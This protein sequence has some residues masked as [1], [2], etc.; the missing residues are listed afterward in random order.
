M[1]VSMRPITLFVFLSALPV[2]GARVSVTLDGKAVD[3]AEVCRWKAGPTVNPAT[4]FFTSSTVECHASAEDVPADSN[5][6]AR[7]GNALIS[8]GPDL[9]LVPAAKINATVPSGAALFVYVPRTSFAIPGNV[10]PADT[11]VIPVLVKDGKVIVVANRVNVP[12]GKSVNVAFDAPRANRVDAVVPVVFAPKSDPSIEAPQAVI[13]EKDKPIVALNKGTDAALLFFRDVAPAKLKLSGKRWKTTEVAVAGGPVVTLDPITATQ[14]SKLIVNWWGSRAPDSLA[15]KPNDCKPSKRAFPYMERWSTEPKFVALVSNCAADPSR[16]GTRAQCKEMARHDLEGPALRGTFEIEDVPAGNYSI[17]IHHPGLP[18]IGKR[19]EVTSAETTAVDVPLSYIT[20]FGKITRAGKP[21]HAMAFN[22]VTDPETGAYDAVVTQIPLVNNMVEV[23]PCDGSATYKFVLDERPKE[24]AAFDIVMP[25]NRIHVE[26]YDKATGA[27]VSKASVGFGA[28]VPGEKFSAH[29]M[30][31][32]GETDDD[33]KM[34]ISPVLQNRMVKVCASREDYEGP[35]EP[36]FKMEDADKTVR[37]GLAKIAIRHGRVNA[38]P[39]S[40]GQLVWVS[41]TTGSITEMLRE[42]KED[43]SFVYKKEHP[44]GEI[45]A[46]SAA[47]RPLYAFIQPQVAADGMFEITLPAAPVRSFTVTLADTSKERSA[48]VELSI[49]NVV[50]PGAGLAS[51]FMFR[52]MQSSLRPGE[53]LLVPDILETGPIRVILIPA[54][55]IEVFRGRNLP[56]VPEIG[57]FPSQLVG[58]GNAV[59]F[60]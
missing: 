22:A 1:G 11:D 3:G 29:F 6:F 34:V 57:S 47:E 55:L 32:Y 7:S 53:T 21:V 44:A 41:P 4:R 13:G 9:K 58:P 48:D 39:F 2:F 50:V 28:L 35:C 36:E 17:E 43:G 14:T 26:V 33:G 31:T 18:L 27:P 23:M 5:V 8:A 38:V 30:S 40:R 19:F 20:F 15:A 42:F 46:F 45:V 59:M 37:L 10:I 49:G 51:H 25:D 54:S 16:P 52:R 56:N 12:A 24:N 60:P